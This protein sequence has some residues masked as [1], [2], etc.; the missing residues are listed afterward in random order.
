MSLEKWAAANLILGGS[1]VITGKQ[2]G[3]QN[4]ETMT[5]AADIFISGRDCGVTL[6]G[7]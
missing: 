7:S 5:F 1:A 4:I 6:S 3:N 2:S